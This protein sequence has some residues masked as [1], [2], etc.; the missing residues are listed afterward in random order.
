MPQQPREETNSAQ[1][2]SNLMKRRDSPTVHFAE[3]P[4]TRTEIVEMLHAHCGD[5][6]HRMQMEFIRLRLSGRERL[7]FLASDDD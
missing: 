6:F 7:D 1:R 3:Y 2:P 4:E 5:W